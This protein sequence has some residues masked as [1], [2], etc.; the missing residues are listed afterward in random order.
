VTGISWWEADAFCRWFTAVCPDLPPG[1]VIQ[2]PTE[3]Q[4]E[5][6][7]RGGRTVNG[8]APR[9]FPW[10][11]SW[12]G[13]PREEDHANCLSSGTGKV[14]PVGLFP[15]GHSQPFGLWDMAGNICERC[16]DGYGAYAQSA[17]TDP[18]STDY[19]HGHVV[20]G[21]AFD[22]PPL[23]L[24]VSY[25]FGASLASRDERT[26]FRCVAAPG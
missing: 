9:R 14:V 21:G 6:A 20:R 19:R 13:D 17:A 1:W 2:L 3:S 23:N 4:W 24:R 25:R 8:A 15:S 22:S 16:R 5:K 26:G 10:G 12:K 11:E 7:A 18:C